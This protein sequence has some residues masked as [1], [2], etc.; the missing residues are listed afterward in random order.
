MVMLTLMLTL[1]YRYIIRKELHIEPPSQ[2][3]GFLLLLQRAGFRVV[4]V[5]NTHPAPPPPPPPPREGLTDRLGDERGGGGARLATCLPAYMATCLHVYLSM[6]LIFHLL[7]NY[8]IAENKFNNI[9][10]PFYFR[11]G[12]SAILPTFFITNNFYVFYATNY[13]FTLFF[14]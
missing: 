5:V 3:R 1:I 4:G 11:E 10:T 9:P 6:S 12:N 2:S 8:I 13:V 7:R 14:M